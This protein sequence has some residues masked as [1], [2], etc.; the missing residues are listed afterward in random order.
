MPT[1]V[2]PMEYREILRRLKLHQT[3][4]EIHRDTG[5]SR[6]LIRKVRDLATAQGWLASTTLVEEHDIAKHLN[7]HKTKSHSLDQIKAKITEWIECGYTYVVI[8]QLINDQGYDYNEITIRRYIKANFPKANKAVCRRQFNPGETAEVDFGYLGLMY[9]ASEQRHR[10][11]WLFSMRLNYSRYS[12]RELVFGQHMDIFLQCHVHAFE[13]L[14]GVPRKISCDNLK[15]AVVRASLQEPLIT[16]SYQMLAEHYGFLISS[17]QPGKPEHKGGV[18]K[19]IDYVKRNFYPLFIEAQK[20]KGRTS[21]Y[22][23][24]CQTALAQWVITKDLNHQIKYTHA[25]P[26]TLFAEEQPLLLKL[27]FDRW[28]RIRWY[29]PKVGDDW[30]VQLCKAFYSVPYQYIGKKVTAY[31]NTSEVVIFYN[32]EE[33][34]RHQRAKADWERVSNPYH[35]PPNYQEY[36][37]STS[38]GVTNWARLIG[39]FTLSLVE[40]ILNQKNV[41]G[42]RPARALCALSKTYGNSRLN[43]ACERALYYQ[44]YSFSSVKKILQQNLDQLPVDQTTS[45]LFGTDTPLTTTPRYTY[46]RRGLYFDD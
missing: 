8:T 37:T 11:V 1:K 34:A 36:L 4:R 31:M 2:T 38:V 40:I 10:K 28:D 17:N 32:Y 15:A 26:A 6:E 25:T 46:A 30:K 13:Y 41:D 27:R 24:D 44:L 23:A 45:D 22:Y 16:K 29:Q 7:D 18:E 5:Y 20:A 3:I 33:I 9:D 14:G 19:D 43:Q 21:P 39:S 35:A 12:Y 42:L